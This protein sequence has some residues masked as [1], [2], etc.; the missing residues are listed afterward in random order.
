MSRRIPAFLARTA[1]S[2]WR[3]GDISF[4]LHTALFGAAL[5]ALGSTPTP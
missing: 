1:V 3:H 2:W 5:L 4:A